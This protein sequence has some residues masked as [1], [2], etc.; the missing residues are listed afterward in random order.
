VPEFKELS[1]DV[2]TGRFPDGIG[3]I[4]I[5]SWRND[6]KQVLQPSL[7]ALQN[8]AD[9][10]AL[11]LD[12]RPNGGGSEPFAA[13]VAGCF[14][15]HP[16]VYAKDMYRDPKSPG[17]WGPVRDRS[18]KPNADQPR[19]AGRIA[20]LMGQV[21]LSSCESFLLMMK[22]V[23]NAKLIGQKS[24]G[25]SGNPKPHDLGNG[26]TV[27]LPSWKAF[28]PDGSCLEGQGIEPDIAVDAT[29]QEIRARDPVL[30]AAR[31]WVDSGSGR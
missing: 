31:K 3:Y 23:P 4:L 9:T 5:K 30:E 1:S 16:V 22:Q 7:Q 29:A 19:Y 13:K 11:I 18:L 25:S 24:Y 26:V 15:D 28:R 6:E 17:G 8:L 2:S 10:R 21:N 20:V 27:W 14:V 12:V